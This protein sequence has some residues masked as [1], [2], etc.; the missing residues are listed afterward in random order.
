MFGGRAKRTMRIA[1]DDVFLLNYRSLC[2]RKI[3]KSLSPE[4][5]G[6]QKLLLLLLEVSF[7][8]ISCVTISTVPDNRASESYEMSMGEV[9]LAH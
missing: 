1:H 7:I 9:A 4:P 2:N 3:R 6:G 8:V 5:V